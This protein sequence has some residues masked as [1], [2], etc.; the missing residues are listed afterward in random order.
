MSNYDGIDRLS[1][2]DHCIVWI[3]DRDRV[4]AEATCTAEADA[5]CRL[6]CHGDCE[7]YSEI[8]RT[9]EQTFDGDIVKRYTHDDCEEGMTPGECNVVLF[10][11]E[12]YCIEE[13]ADG[14]PTFV[15]ARTPIEPVW[16]G[17]YFDWKP[18]TP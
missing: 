16:Q 15:I 10:L 4:T 11:N 17:D 3:F 14:K 18:V 8:H 6:A 9:E 13:S 12:S 2:G 1:P 5:D 7:T